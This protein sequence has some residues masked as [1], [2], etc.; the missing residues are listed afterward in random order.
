MGIRR[1]TTL[2][3]ISY[4]F[5]LLSAKPIKKEK[6]G[7][8]EELDPK[9]R[10]EGEYLRYLGQVVEILEQDEDFKQKLHNATEDDIRSGQIA[11]H[12]DLISHNVRSKLD[13]LKRVEI[14]AQRRIHKQSRDK[15][16]G[17]NERNFWSPLF[18]EN[19]DTFETEDLKKLLKKVL[20]CYLYHTETFVY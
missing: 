1:I 18:D 14:E 5:Y 11:D 9:K 17:I 19:Q 13:E 20:N 2:L 16:N 15:L 7:E 10:E 12:I 3:V 6:K 8:S 4:C